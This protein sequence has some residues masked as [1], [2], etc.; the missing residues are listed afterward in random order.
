MNKQIGLSTIEL[1]I[2]I[3]ISA[4]FAVGILQMGDEVKT[5]AIE[6]QAQQT[7]VQEALKRI[8]GE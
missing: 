6:Y 8:R 3:S 1:L 7:N 4:G 2:T 5:L